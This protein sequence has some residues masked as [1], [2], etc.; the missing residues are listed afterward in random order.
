MGETNEKV[1]GQGSKQA[2]GLY[3]NC[4]G[5]ECNEVDIKVI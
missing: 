1:L 4:K 5:T 3:I 2:P